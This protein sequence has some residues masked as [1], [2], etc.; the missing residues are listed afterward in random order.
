LHLA[1][2]TPARAWGW[3]SNPWWRKSPIF[4]K[5]ENIPILE[6]SAISSVT[7]AVGISQPSVVEKIADFM[8]NGKHSESH[9]FGDFERDGSSRRIDASAWLLRSNVFR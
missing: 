7:D 6:F 4:P 2:V 9:I 8:Q 5:T 1:G 3:L